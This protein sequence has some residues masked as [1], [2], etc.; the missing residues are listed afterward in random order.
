MNRMWHQ[1]TKCVLKFKV[2][3][4]ALINSLYVYIVLYI[5][6]I[7]IL[8]SSPYPIIAYDNISYCLFSITLSHGATYGIFVALH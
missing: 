1:Q 8:S 7:Y 5:L 4:S 6:Y 2:L 3:L